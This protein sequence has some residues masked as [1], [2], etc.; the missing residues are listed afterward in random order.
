MVLVENLLSNLLYGLLLGSIYGI[1]TMG[2]SIIFGVLRIV[3]VGHGAFVMLGAFI[4][5]W[6][7][8]LYGIVPPA[9][10]F[11]AAFVGA[12]LGFLMFYSA[13]RRLIDAPELSTL[14]AT[15]G[16]GLFVEEFAKF[17]WGPEYY[18]YSWNVG[19]LNMGF[20]TI[21]FTKILAA[22]LSLVLAV[23][24]YAFIKKTKF[25]M[26]IRAVVEDKEGAL[27]CGIN[28]DRIYALSFSL[29]IALT[30]V[31][32]V[33]VA[34]FTPVGINVYMGGDYTLKAFVIAVLGGLTS[35]IGSFYAGI[36]FGLFENGSYTLLGLIPGIEPFAMTRFIAF[37]FLLLILLVRPTGIIR[38]EE[39]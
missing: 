32:G 30:V 19:S 22:L 35:P 10:V 5:F 7:F 18:G 25:G 13:I 36:L 33:L 6:L 14:L 4:T 28:V 23:T 1:A 27:A 38:G 3:N 31:G 17:L 16:F 24:V 12:A 9:A 8:A 29:G 11:F 15:F 21:P 39:L 37:A 26:A 34:T 20:T 2:L